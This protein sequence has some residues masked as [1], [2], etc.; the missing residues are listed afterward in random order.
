MKQVF[1]TILL[2]VFPVSLIL[3]SGAVAGAQN[4]VPDSSGS[5]SQATVKEGARFMLGGSGGVVDTS[6]PKKTAADFTWEA[7]SKNGAANGSNPLIGRASGKP[8]YDFND[9]RAKPLLVKP[10]EQA[11]ADRR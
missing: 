3:F 4:A 8:F 1:R 7:L 6:T 11:H 10:A 5:S 9:E 2:S